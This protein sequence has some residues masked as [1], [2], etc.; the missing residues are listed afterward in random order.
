[1]NIASRVAAGDGKG[2]RLT[3]ESDNIEDFVREVVER[4]P[5]EFYIQDSEEKDGNLLS[6]IAYPPVKD[7]SYILP[8]KINK[9]KDE[10]VDVDRK[11]AVLL[12]ALG[13]IDPAHAKRGFHKK[14]VISYLVNGPNPINGYAL[15]T[16]DTAAYEISDIIEVHD[17][18]LALNDKQ[19]GQ[20]SELVEDH[21]SEEEDEVNEG[22]EEEDS[23]SCSTPRDRPIRSSRR[24]GINYKEDNDDDQG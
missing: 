2:G 7:V 20:D 6:L 22:E 19:G 14:H 12:Q 10:D 8:E 13:S 4:M 11:Q 16:F 1:M 17:S 23:S 18:I 24:K 15:I 9:G 21:D 5:Q 3:G